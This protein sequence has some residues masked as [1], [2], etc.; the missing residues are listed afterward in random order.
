MHFDWIIVGGGSAGCVL[1]NRLSSTSRNHVLLIEAGPDHAGGNEDPRFRDIY[2]GHVAFDPVLLWTDIRA[3]N[4][5]GGNSRPTARYE[6]ARILGGGSA[7]N[8]QVANRGT[9]ADY[10]EWEQA[11][12]AGW[13]WQ[14]V[15]PYFCRL[16]TDEF[17][18]ALHGD[19]EPIPITRVPEDV[20]PGFSRTAKRVFEGLGFVDIVDQNA[21]FEDGCFALPLSNDG[22]LRVS[23]AHGYLS[24]DVRGR[25][26][27][28]ILSDCEVTNPIWEAHRVVGVE[29]RTP[30]GITQ[31][32]ANRTILSMG[33]I[34]SPAFLMRSGIGDPASLS[35]AG[36]PTRCA[37]MGVGRNLQEH[38]GISVS[39][40][41]DSD[42]RNR[43]TRRHGVLGLRRSS[44]IDGCPAGD[45]F[46]MVLSKSAWHPLG[47]RIGT[48]LSWINKPFSRGEV[49]LRV[50]PTD[51]L[52][53]EADINLL[54]DER[55]L[56]RLLAEVKFLSRCIQHELFAG[57][58]SDAGPSVYSGAAKTLGKVTWLNFAKTTIAASLFDAA[59]GLRS[60][61]LRDYMSAGYSLNGLA[62]SDDTIDDFLRRSVFGQWHA[63][64]TCRMGPPDDRFAVVDP[65]SASVH[66]IGGLH[67]IDASVMPSIPR[68]N[69]NI[70]VVMVA[71]KFSTRLLAMDKGC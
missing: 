16:E 60:R 57:I 15:L 66:K 70:P 14:S 26:N 55:D 36:L 8:G 65:A 64:G 44:G 21:C 25:A 2:P 34:H 31:F 1:A 13:N 68:A 42:A 23:T 35:A 17:S 46:S 67:V 29:A 48:I 5:R 4:V 11:G 39:A 12:A 43:L 33:A 69:L 30:T 24:S 28:T 62:K 47:D 7:I 63:C 45:M 22:E 58:V 27:L 41:L 6:Q 32:Q 59:P 61:M 56:Q 37:L 10:D 49:R 38:A 52:V 53:T 20:W 54:S 19:H 71:E 51:G 3:S 40:Y 9:P 18:G 50:D